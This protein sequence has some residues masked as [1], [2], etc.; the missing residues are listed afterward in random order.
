MGC[1]LHPPLLLRNRGLLQ[2][3]LEFR[4]SGI[5]F[6]VWGFGFRVWGFGVRAQ[7]FGFESWGLRFIIENSGF[8]AQS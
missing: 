7:D 2:P 1:G 4:V 6:G 5:G 8:V 3:G